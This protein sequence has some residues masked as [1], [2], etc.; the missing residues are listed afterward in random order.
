MS[1]TSFHRHFK[2][3]T[4]ESPL[5]Y[6]RHLRLIE[7][8]RRLASGSVTVTETAFASGYASAA[9]FSREYKRLFG[10]APYLD[11]GLLRQA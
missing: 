8:R 1:V 9:Q 2:I 3:V 11:L 5:A 10:T 7:A 4:G 6:Q